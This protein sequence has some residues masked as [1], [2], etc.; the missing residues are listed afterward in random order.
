VF[1]VSGALG[2]TVKSSS[3]TESDGLIGI[4]GPPAVSVT[5]DRLVAW[6]GLLNSA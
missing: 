3:P 5:Y 2:V 1:G 4:A 6:T